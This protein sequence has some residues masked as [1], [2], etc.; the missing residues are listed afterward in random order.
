DMS[1]EVHTRLLWVFEGITSYYDDLA[2][3]RAGVVSLAE[4][5]ELLAGNLTRILRTP[6]R[7]RQSLTDSSFDAWTKF[8]KQ[9]EN[10]PN[11]IISYYAKGAMVAL[12]L[13]LKL[14]SES[15]ITLD[16]VMRECW[17]RF[18]LDD[19]RGMPESGLE[20]VVA[21][22]TGKDW[23]AFFDQTLRST[24]D[25]DLTDLLA[26]V[27]IHYEVRVPT[28]ADDNGGQHQQ[29]PYGVF[30]GFRLDP[31][32]S[33]KVAL[34]L[35]DSPA[36]RAGLSA[37]DTVVAV[38]GRKTDKQGIDA[39]LRAA[40]PGDALDIHVFR[41]DALIQVTLTL[42][43]PLADIVSLRIGDDETS[44]VIERRQRWL[45]ASRWT[46]RHAP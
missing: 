34:V 3:V 46:D 22:L 8:Y 2:L 11:A 40:R 21:D 44:E 14:R 32:Q 19:P 23:T 35:N 6:G 31:R 10:G 38:N 26:T 33:S 27:G 24:T 28:S 41:Y 17:Q 9:D 15:E 18:Y 20:D 30:A 1:Q 42:A 16:D 25:F 43:E 36:S 12:A 4:Y 29:P 7:L 45:H 13:D 5:S 37:G 39:T